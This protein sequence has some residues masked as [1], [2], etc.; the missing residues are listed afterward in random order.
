MTAIKNEIDA[1]EIIAA[2]KARPVAIN[3]VKCEKI[4]V[5]TDSSE[6][7]FAAVMEA[8]R[9]ARA[10]N[11]ELTILTVVDYDKDVAAFEQVSL[12]GYVPAELK[13]AAYKYLA[14]I[15][16]AIPPEIGAHTRLEVGA[17]SE[18]IIEV[19]TEENSDLIC[20]GSR[21]L[22]TVESLL[23]GGVSNH[24]LKY[25]PVPVLICK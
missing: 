6:S 9:L 10:T 4:L 22:G 7:A 8:V 20:M 18:K 15:M 13:I 14:D 21:G 19:A 24:V 12:S 25:S 17:P 23:L 3:N 2:I 16:H 1:K 11:A 5:P